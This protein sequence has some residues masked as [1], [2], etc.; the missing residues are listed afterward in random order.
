MSKSL[1]EIWPMGGSLVPGQVAIKKTLAT[2]HDPP[3]YFLD[4]LLYFTNPPVGV[5]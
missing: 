4:I 5:S 2:P 3:L 1:W